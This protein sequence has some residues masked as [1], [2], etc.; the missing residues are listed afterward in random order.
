MKIQK[1]INIDISDYYGNIENIPVTFNLE[2]NKEEILTI[3]SRED[4]LFVFLNNINNFA[5]FLKKV[6]DKIIKEMTEKAYNTLIDF[7]ENWIKKIK[8]IREK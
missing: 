6:P 5:S 8:E 3:L 2:L 7:F 4:G 1:E